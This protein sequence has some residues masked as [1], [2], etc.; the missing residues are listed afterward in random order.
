MATTNVRG[1]GHL[2]IDVL[3]LS[4][5]CPSSTAKFASAETYSFRGWLLAYLDNAHVCNWD[6]DSY[7]L[8][9]TL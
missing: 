3:V 5:A 7:K 9:E 2:A 8:L 6:G 4:L 1:A